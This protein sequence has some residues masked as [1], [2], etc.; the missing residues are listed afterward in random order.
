[1]VIG[2]PKEIKSQEF[3][4]GLTPAGAQAL[5]SAGHTVYVQ[6]GAGIG[7]G[8]TD[9]DYEKAGAHILSEDRKSVV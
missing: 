8:F 4:V 5:Q 3:R 1:M 2:V 9:S 6:Q 7:S